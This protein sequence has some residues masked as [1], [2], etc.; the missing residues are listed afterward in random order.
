MLDVT[1]IGCG[2]IG[3]T[4]LQRLAGHA[5]VRITHVVVTDSHVDDVQRTL[6]DA[7]RVVCDVPAD[8]RLVIECAGHE[9]LTAH[10]LPAL[11]RGVECA[12]LSVGALSA[13]GLAEQLADAAARGRTQVHL[14]AGAIGGVDAIAAARLAGLERVTYT[15]RKPPAGWRGTAAEAVVDL[16]ALAAPAVIL[17]ASAR[18]AARLYPKNA[19]VA[20]TVSLAG[21]GLDATRVRLIADPT[22]R[23]NIHEIEVEGAF[24][25]M[26][27]TMC[28]RPLP[29][30]PKTS[31]LT[32][33]SALRFLDNRT[34]A[35]TI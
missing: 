1:L 21:L 31:A 9:A 33:L 10:V 2:A 34:S 29:D 24:G 12:V 7:V 20:A 22:V 19:N 17:E 13:P 4:L 27:V 14:L 16:D 5:G 28:G 23:D 11:A 6:G 3:R 32:V 30:N 8:A 26:Q 35:M 25:R 18:E 15:G